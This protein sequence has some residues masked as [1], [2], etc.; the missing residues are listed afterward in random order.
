[1]MGQAGLKIGC[2]IVGVG[3]TKVST[4]VGS[5]AFPLRC[6][7]LRMPNLFFSFSCTR[8]LSMQ[9]HHARRSGPVVKAVVV[10]TSYVLWPCWYQAELQAALEALPDGAKVRPPPHTCAALV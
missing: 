7:E 8:C 4:L 1:M 9:G 3:K 6:H 10:P 2:I 5:T